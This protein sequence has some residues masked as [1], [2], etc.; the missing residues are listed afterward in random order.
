MI[1]RGTLE[2]I[3]I[4][5]VR[6]QPMQSVA[7]VAATTNGGLMGDRF[8]Q[9]AVARPKTIKQLTLIEAEAIE[10]ATREYNVQFEPAQSRRN[11]LTR[12]VPLNHLVGHTFRIG[13]VVLRGLELCE[14]CGHLEKLTIAGIRKA[15]V[16][17]GGLRAEILSGGTLRVGDSIEHFAMDEVHG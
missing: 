11:L 9:S 5:P 3:H 16:H 17:R 2:A 1:F 12:G 15:L 7:E 8:D 10:A 14:P 4:A 13:D 6:A